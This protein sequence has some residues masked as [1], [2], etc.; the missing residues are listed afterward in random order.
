[1]KLA[2]LICAVGCAVATMGNAQVVT[3]SF[4]NL[5]W[6]GGTAPDTSKWSTTAESDRGPVRIHASF[7]VVEAI[8]SSPLAPDLAPGFAQTLSSFDAGNHLSIKSDII[9]VPITRRELTLVLWTIRDS[10]RNFSGLAIYARLSARERNLPREHHGNQSAD[11]FTVNSGIQLQTNQEIR[12]EWDSPTSCGF[13]DNGRDDVTDWQSMSI[14]ASI[15]LVHRKCNWN[16]TE[17][18][19]IPISFADSVLITIARAFGGD[20]SARVASLAFLIRRK[21]LHK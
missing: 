21:S 3:N 6:H 10:W 15:C 14:V 9:R 16:R 12:I 11:L 17:P 2:A 4:A 7:N 5:H 18:R 13:D 1:M 20:F 19:P 8:W